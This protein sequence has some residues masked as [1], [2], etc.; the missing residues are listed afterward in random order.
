MD[1]IIDTESFIPQGE[2]ETFSHGVRQRGTVEITL[3]G[4][5]RRVEA[6]LWD[7][8]QLI[9]R[10]IVGKYQTGT[11]LWPAYVSV[12]LNREG[13]TERVRFGRYDNHPKFRKNAIWFA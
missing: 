2:P 11:K 8:G 5:T 9:A 12:Y 13:E 1:R 6:Y 10:G 3:R 4:E 7:D